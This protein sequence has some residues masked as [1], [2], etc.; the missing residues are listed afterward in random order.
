MLAR[1]HASIGLAVLA[2]GGE[3]EKVGGARKTMVGGAVLEKISGGAEITSTDSMK[4]AGAYVKIEASSS[5]TFTCGEAS[6]KIGDGGIE[7]V[8]PLITFTAP[9]ISL[10]QDTAEK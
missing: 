5:I 9:N 6:V 2:S 10:P 4:I 3:V 7:I 8:A 1:Q